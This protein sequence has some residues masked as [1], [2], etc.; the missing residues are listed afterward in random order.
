MEMLTASLKAVQENVDEI[1]IT[2]NSQKPHVLMG[3]KIIYSHHPNNK[4]VAYGQNLGIKYAIDNN[5]DW[6]IFFDQDSS[7]DNVFLKK[8]FSSFSIIQNYDNHTY[9]MGPMA[10]NID[11]GVE[12]NKKSMQD[13]VWVNSKEYIKVRELMCS[14]SVIRT[15]LFK[16]IGLMDESLFIDGVDFEICWRAT[17]KLDAHFYL[18]KDC[19]L[20]HQL[21]E[22]DKRI[23][24]RNCHI[25]TPFR[26]YYQVRNS[27]LLSKRRY[28][29]MKWKATE[30]TKSLG[31]LLLFP[32]FLS[33]HR[34]YL[35]NIL[36]GGYDGFINK[37][38][39]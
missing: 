15:Q 39:L 7:F 10:V 20:K 5:F 11:S 2:D 13:S 24:G 28:V 33:P 38:S 3:K 37:T 1:W 6:I 23:L 19:I 35:K 12:L 17:Y 9:G 29:P 16:Q 36:K 8:L 18:T 31:K 21:G 14:A 32:V 27:I 26:T 25:P 30:I 34:L 22:G 4:G